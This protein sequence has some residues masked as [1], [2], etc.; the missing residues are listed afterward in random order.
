MALT[1]SSRRRSAR[2]DYVYWPLARPFLLAAIAMAALLAGLL[3]VGVFSYA[4]GKLGIGPQAAALVLIAS[5]LGS[6]VN[7]PVAR[8]RDRAVRLEPY[9]SVF[10][11]RY[12]VPVLRRSTTILAV[13]VGGAIIPSALSAY[14]IAHDRLGWQAFAAVVIVAALVYLVARPVRGLGIA[15]PAL[16]PG[17]FAVLTAL[18]LHPAA[19]AGLAY[20]GGTLGTLLGAD[21]ANLGKVR[22]LGA[23]VASIGGAGTFDGVFL[24]GITAVLFAALL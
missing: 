11:I 23:P 6:A 9:L 8:F 15:V 3:L 20:V 2:P 1:A 19:L 4:L 16:L 24:A 14:L 13:N 18:L 7:I 17:L 12:L 21:L 22:R 10:G 5:V